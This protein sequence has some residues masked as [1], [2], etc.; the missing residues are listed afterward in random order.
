MSKLR[1]VACD[2]GNFELKT[3]AGG[4]PTAI[5]SIH[6]KLPKGVNAL[7]AKPTSPIIEVSGDRY[8]FGLQANKYSSH[9][10]TVTQSKELLAQLHLYASL[11]PSE[12]TF[13]LVVSHHSPDVVRSEL[14][15]ALS[16]TH[17]YRRNG[18]D[19]SIKIDEVHVV[20]EG[21]GTYWLAKSAGLTPSSGHTV[22]IDIGG[23]SWLYR[24][25]DQDGEIIAQSVSDRLGSFALAA[26]IAHDERLREPLRKFG[27]TQPDAGVVMDG[28]RLGHTYAET[29]VSWRQWLDDYRLPWFKQILGGV[30]AELTNLLPYCRGFVLTGGGANLVSDRIVNVDSFEIIQN[31]NFSNVLGMYQEYA[32]QS[33]GVTA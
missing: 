4:E 29:A 28:F 9:E 11:E 14:T 20:P 32:D 7:S 33:V 19:C 3:C 2:F 5:R 26:N 17:R 30:K 25:I 1:T 23:G 8:H 13:R 22:I 31:P 24:V 27:I 12:G 6:F 10:K 18:H 15:N 21:Y 16:G